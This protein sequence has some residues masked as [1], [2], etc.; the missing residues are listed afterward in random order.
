MAARRLILVG[1]PDK[2]QTVP[3]GRQLLGWLAG[4]AEVVA[5]NIEG[6]IDPEDY[7]R[8]EFVVVLGGDGT[9][10]STVRGLGDQQRPIIG[11]NIGKLGF[12]AEFSVAQF[13][14][15]LERILSDE[16][17]ISRRVM[18][19][20]DIS[21]PQRD[22]SYRI[23]AVNELAIT[24]GPPFRMIEVSIG[25]GPE[26]L[27]DCA[28]D[29]LVVATPTGSTAYNLSA[30]GPIVQAAL[31]AAV[32]TPLAAHSLNFRPMVV[33]LD[34]PIVLRCLESAWGDRR[35]DPPDPSERP[36]CESWGLAVASVDGQI[37]VPLRNQD[38]VTISRSKDYF[39]LVHN[40]RQSQWR[41]LSTK[42]HW[43]MLP[44]YRDTKGS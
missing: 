27:A 14:Q 18:L 26:H 1:N 5:E 12:L 43:G 30:G 38:V 15:H 17:L 19:Q 6:R 20:C 31:E 13:Q 4:R 22:Q 3:L 21:G 11:V 9:I 16:S 35:P 8:A 24:S 37:N 29:G 32:I 2:P 34:A 44:N 42:L 41:L 25:I 39:R 28:G 7:R 33:T 23:R 40:P 10:L 36:G